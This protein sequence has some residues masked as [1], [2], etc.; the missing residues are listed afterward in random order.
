MHR[1]LMSCCKTDPNVGLGP[2]TLVWSKL[3]SLVSCRNEQLLLT[4]ALTA[5][6]SRQPAQR[7]RFSKSTVRHEPVCLAH[8]TQ[9]R[10]NAIAE[11]FHILK[12]S[13]FERRLQG[14]PFGG[15]RDPNVHG[16]S[17]TGRH[18]IGRCP[19]ARGQSTSTKR[20]LLDQSFLTEPRAKI[21]SISS[22]LPKT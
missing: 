11:Q 20:S 8:R 21:W 1:G 22:I 3:A 15:A 19:V 18:H 16:H 2:G 14:L 13:L 7:P 9:D 6:A 10:A 4:A 12:S 5:P 17:A